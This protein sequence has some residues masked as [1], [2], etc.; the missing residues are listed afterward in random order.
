MPFSYDP[1]IVTTIDEVRLKIGDTNPLDPQL[2]DEEI[3]M[4]LTEAGESSRAAA[5][6]AIDIL[7]ARYARHVDKWVGDL[8][9]LAS[10]RFEQYTK[11][12][13]TLITGGGSPAMSGVPNAGGVY[14]AE[15][16]SARANTALVQGAF[17]VGLHDN[18]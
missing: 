7:I 2:M 13:G 14:I 4:L 17:R 5:V 8:K 6:A 10:Q 9:I 3:T 1:A 11:L 12:R 15:T 18:R 16:L